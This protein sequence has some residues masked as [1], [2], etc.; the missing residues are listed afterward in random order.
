M[1][2]W[3]EHTVSSV[4]EPE[5]NFVAMNREGVKNGC[6]DSKVPIKVCSKSRI[7]EK[8]TKSKSRLSR[9][10]NTTECLSQ[11]NNLLME[12]QIGNYLLKIDHPHL[13]KT[14]FAM[15]TPS[16]KNSWKRKET[17]WW[18]CY[19]KTK[20]NHPKRCKFSPSKSLQTTKKKKLRIITSNYQSS[21]MSSQK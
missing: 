10:R 7:F 16:K 2:G 17:P 20:K 18:I 19:K 9:V 3:Q 1:S 14:W 4:K 12:C 21:R 5:K 13:S 6:V 11:T 15:S 8:T